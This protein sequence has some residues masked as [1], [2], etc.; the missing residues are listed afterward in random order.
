RRAT[1]RNERSRPLM[2]QI[3]AWATAQAQKTLPH[4][5]LGKA[6][7]YVLKLWPGLTAFLDDARI[8]IDNNLVER[9]QRGIVV[10]RRHHYGSRSRR[11]TEVAALFYGVI[12]PCKLVS[13][14]PRAYL[15]QASRALLAGRR[16]L[17][18]PHQVA[19]DQG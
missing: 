1:L 9:L 7:G 2:A 12:E 3:H 14:E 6:I 11:G 5:A 17:P 16:L 4:S 15:R 8:P 13:L 19:A 18:L 10:G